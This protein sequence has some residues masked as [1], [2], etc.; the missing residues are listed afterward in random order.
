MRLQLRRPRV[1]L[2]FAFDG[3]QSHAITVVGSAWLNMA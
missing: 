3:M 2:H 1:R